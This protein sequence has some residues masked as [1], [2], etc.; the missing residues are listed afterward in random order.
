[1]GARSTATPASPLVVLAAAFALGCADHPQLSAPHA[2]TAGFDAAL[3]VVTADTARPDARSAAP[4]PRAALGAADGAVAPASVLSIADLGRLPQHTNA[5]SMDINRAG[6]V[7]GVSDTPEAGPTAHAFLWSRETGMVDLGAILDPEGSSE[8]TAI[9]D[10]GQVV[11]LL[12]ALPTLGF[13]WDA[14]RGMREFGTPPGYS[15]ARFIPAAINNSAQVVGRVERVVSTPDDEATQRHAFLWQDGQWVNLGNL[16]GVPELAGEAQ[17]HDINDAGHV[18]GQSVTPG[19]ATHAFRWTRE[20]GMVDLGAL[21]V[22]TFPLGRSVAYAINDADQVV[23]EVS[24]DEGPHPFLWEAGVGVQDLGTL[25]GHD[26]AENRATDVNNAGQVVGTSQTAEGRTHGFLW[27]RGLGMIDLVPLPDH[28]GAEA[29]AVDDSGRVAGQSFTFL[30]E[31]TFSRATLWTVGTG[32]GAPPRVDRLAA[33]VLPPGVVP[34]LSGV[35]LR[36]R[37]TDPNDAGPWDW[38]I[39]W[40]DGTVHTPQ[41]VRRTGEFAFLRAA[42]YISAGPHTITVTA[43]DPSG[44]TSA[45]AAATVP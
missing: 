44:L 39:D 24:T 6:Q 30:G 37:L 35:W 2:V 17:A 27:Q 43:T 34:G 31:E 40:G 16:G 5:R 12:D 18:V 23:G 1:M 13:L 14:N 41:D 36:V 8:A 38:R 7:V 29:R 32:A 45:P 10:S 4:G 20:E 26:F 33:V 9:N 19:G 15:F 21:P 11:G 25:G 42:P 22:T 3:P 28:G